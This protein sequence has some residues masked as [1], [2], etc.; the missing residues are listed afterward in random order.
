MANNLSQS[1]FK[2]SQRPDN[3]D[4][5]DTLW[6]QYVSGPDVSRPTVMAESKYKCYRI[7]KRPF[8]PRSVGSVASMI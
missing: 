1:I 5:V 3:A 8:Q 2:P 7:L 4:T 6:R